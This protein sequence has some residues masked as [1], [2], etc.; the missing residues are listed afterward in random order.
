MFNDFIDFTLDGLHVK[1]TLDFGSGPTP[2]LAELLKPI[3][4][5]IPAILINEEANFLIDNI[6]MLG[7]QRGMPWEHYLKEM[8]KT[9]EQIKKDLEKDATERVKNR[10]IIQEIIKEIGKALKAYGKKESTVCSTKQLAEWFNTEIEGAKRNGRKR[11][12]HLQIARAIRNAKIS[13]STKMKVKAYLEANSGY[14][15][16]EISR[17]SGLSR[18]TIYKYGRELGLL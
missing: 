10:L 18:T 17:I 3:Q 15:I 7:L 12:E 5:D 6:K 4:C 2:V 11:E 8:K 14:S 13:T 16:S 1:N 9:E